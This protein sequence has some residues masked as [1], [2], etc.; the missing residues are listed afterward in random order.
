[1]GRRAQIHTQKV[2]EAQE[3]MKQ[4]NTQQTRKGNQGKQEVVGSQK[5]VSPAL[6][7]PGR[8]KS[9]TKG[10]HVMEAVTEH[11]RDNLP[12]QLRD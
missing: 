5:G 4:M 3:S 1:M 8:E 2:I 12:S 7:I 11:N 6:M 9:M 10:V